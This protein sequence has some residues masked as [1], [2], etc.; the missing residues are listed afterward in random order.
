[1]HHIN[2]GHTSGTNQH[3]TDFKQDIRT[4]AWILATAR[5]TPYRKAAVC[6]ETEE[7]VQLV[8]GTQSGLIQS[9][10]NLKGK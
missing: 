1:M 6:W 10:G 7:Q 8:S 9:A 2:L 5:V 3:Q 4:A